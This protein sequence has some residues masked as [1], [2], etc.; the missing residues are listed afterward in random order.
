VPEHADAAVRIRARLA[1]GLLP[2]GDV[3]K[4]LVVRGTG[5]ACEGCETPITAEDRLCLVQCTGS[6]VE[7]HMHPACVAIWD[8]QCRREP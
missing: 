1:K 5:A 3:K 8:F 7:L 4:V 6:D 2:R